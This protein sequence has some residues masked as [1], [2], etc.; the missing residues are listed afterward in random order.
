MPIFNM[1][2]FIDLKGNRFGRLIVIGQSSHRT[3]SGIL[4]WVCKCDCGNEKTISGISLRSGHTKSCGCYRLEK[5]KK[6]G[7]CTRKYKSPEYT[8]YQ[9]M[10]CR[11][12]NPKFKGYKNYGGR[13]IAVCDRWRGD[14]GFINFLSDMGRRPSKDH[15]LERIDNENGLYSK[16]NCKWDTWIVQGGNRRN[17]RWIE[18]NGTNMILSDWARFF[19]LPRRSMLTT[20]LY[21]HSF[22]EAFIHYTENYKRRKA[23]Q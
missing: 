3:N 21:N 8:T 10:I 2:H 18:Y 22:E 14:N 23:K 19:K 17:N 12:Y 1:S 9:G 7:E 6:H 13:G 5:N 16:E 11:C 20:Y 15:T 4:K